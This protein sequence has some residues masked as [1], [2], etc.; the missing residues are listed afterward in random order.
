MENCSRCGHQL[1]V[2]RFCTNC[3]HPI[4]ARNP[5]S[6]DDADTAERPLGPMPPPPP[7]RSALPPPPPQAPPVPP[8]PAHAP[9]PVARYP[10]FA[11]Q[12]APAAPLPVVRPTVPT[13]HRRPRRAWLPWA[14]ATGL[15]LVL[16]AVLGLVLLFDD[17]GRDTAADPAAST[18]AETDPTTP[19]GTPPSASPTPSTTP[20][21]GPQDVARF[22]TVEVPA[23]APPN[24]DVSG[25][26]VRYEGRNM[27]DGVPET[28][29]RMPGDGTGAEITLTLA[30]PTTISRVG[31]INGYAKTAGRLDWYA[32]NRRILAV[33][34]VFDDGS[35]VAQDLTETRDLQ[36]VD[37]DPI[38]TSTITLRLLEV[39]KP[40]KGPAAR[41]YTPI[42]DVELV[43]TP[44]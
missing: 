41:N 1:G 17:P 29:W 2:G 23:T 7:P 10:L 43:G 38:T 3:G 13:E 40:G 22:A 24:Q 37:V 26:Q 15:A 33:Q 28:C 32:G 16:V 35:V 5:A 30:E 44:G 27:L 8:P 25:N 19:D 11:D 36:S 6:T 12:V 31:L 20:S 9:P 14:I 39:S 4:E 18:S 34:W 42:S 21:G